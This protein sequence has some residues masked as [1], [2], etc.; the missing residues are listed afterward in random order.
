MPK[1]NLA[2]EDFQTTLERINSSQDESDLYAEYVNS[3][4]VYEETIIGDYVDLEFVPIDDGI[5]FKPLLLQEQI[6]GHWQIHVV[7]DMQRCNQILL[8]LATNSIL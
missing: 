7:I 2:N 4:A 3:E 1:K 5:T 8:D 6:E